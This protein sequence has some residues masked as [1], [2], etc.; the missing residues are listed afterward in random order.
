[1]RLIKGPRSWEILLNISDAKT[2]TAVIPLKDAE[3]LDVAKGHRLVAHFSPQ[4][5]IIA[6]N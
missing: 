5:V 2:L 6:A 1:L 4:D 3:K